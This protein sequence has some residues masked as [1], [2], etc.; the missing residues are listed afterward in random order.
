MKRILYSLLF[1]SCLASA[2]SP[3]TVN[4][5]STTYVQN[6]SSSDLE[7]HYLS[8]SGIINGGNANLCTQKT[9]TLNHGSS[10]SANP[11][12][13][14]APILPY[15][16]LSSIIDVKTGKSQSFTNCRNNGSVGVLT[17]TPLVDDPNVF[18]CSSSQ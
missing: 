9:F 18:V 10:N 5:T 6:L 2:V 4:Q 3:N 12:V 1:I 14:Q 8:C 13:I 17:I 7:V 16:I 15:V 11:I